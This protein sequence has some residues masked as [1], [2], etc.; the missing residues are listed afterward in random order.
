MEASSLVDA[1]GRHVPED[2]VTLFAPLLLSVPF[3]IS[4]TLV[5]TAFCTVHMTMGKLGH[6]KISRRP[7]GQEP[8]LLLARDF[9]IHGSSLDRA[10]LPAVTRNDHHEFASL[11][12]A[13]S[14]IPPEQTQY[15]ERNVNERQQG[16]AAATS[17][18]EAYRHVDILE[19]AIPEPWVVTFRDKVRNG[20]RTH[21][22]M[23]DVSSISA[24]QGE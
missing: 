4:V 24:H 9:R 17:R 20:V 10:D 19:A 11:R 13:V 1:I 22:P 12:L 23:S 14:R 6:D 18:W 2:V 3:T 7:P 16:G 15:L 5:E 8:D 21:A